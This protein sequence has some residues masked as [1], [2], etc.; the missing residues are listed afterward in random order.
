MFLAIVLISALGMT[1]AA[2][3]DSSGKIEFQNDC[4]DGTYCVVFHSNYPA[5]TM[6][7]NSMER[8][9]GFSAGSSF[10]TAGKQL[11]SFPPPTDSKYVFSRW[12]ALANGSGG[13]FDEKTVINK[14]ITVYAQ[15][16]LVEQSIPPTEPPPEPPPPTPTPTPDPETPEPEPETPEPEIPETPKPEPGG[17]VEPPPAG[18]TTP[19]TTAPNTSAPPT[20]SP[21]SPPRVR[22]A[23]PLVLDGEDNDGDSDFEDNVTIVGPVTELPP[24]RTPQRAS[25]NENLSEVDFDAIIEDS[26]QSRQ[27]EQRIYEQEVPRI[28][29][30][31]WEIPIFP[32]LGEGAWALLNLILSLLGVVFAIVCAIRAM[33]LRNRE[34]EEAMDDEDSDQSGERIDNADKA[35]QRGK[36][37]RVGWL[38][39]MIILGIAGIFIFLI[40]QDMKGIMVL[41]DIWTIVHAVIFVSEII[42]VSMAFKKGKEERQEQT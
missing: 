11:P 12:D 3:T 22:P 34:P 14:C 28:T 27:G 15:W 26:P 42:S 9:T 23:F 39:A 16:R 30:G 29:I 32:P 13:T 25:G 1:S 17:P 37:Y 21:Y 40:T 24:A 19:G 6:L 36:Q 20:T 2:A 18:T 4:L 31:G 7:G 41:V 35:E 38:A 10:K 33:L 8:V 5:G